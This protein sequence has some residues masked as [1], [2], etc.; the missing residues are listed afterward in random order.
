[1]EKTLY[2]GNYLRLTEE[3]IQGH[4]F[5]RVYLKDSVIVF[6][7]DAQGRLL[8]IEEYRAHETPQRRWKTVTGHID[9]GDTPEATVKRELQEEIGYRANSMELLYHQV[10]TGTVN[11]RVWIYLAWDL[12]PSKLPNPDGEETILKVE[13]LETSEWFQRILNGDLAR[14]PTAVELFKLYYSLQS[15]ARTLP[16]SPKT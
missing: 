4:I 6:P 16:P 5:E 10:S 15:G 11:T 8:F 12:E 14:G 7:C 9:P 3:E 13:A 2:Q 1:M